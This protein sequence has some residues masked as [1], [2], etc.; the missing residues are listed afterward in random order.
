MIVFLLKYR[1]RN[2]PAQVTIDAGVIDEEIAGNVLGVRTIHT[3]HIE[4]V[5]VGTVD[6]RP[7]CRKRKNTAVTERLYSRAS[8]FETRRRWRSSVK[9]VESQTRTISRIFSCEIVLPPSV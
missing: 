4:I 5:A 8:I 1:R 3:S 9:S 7:Q 2:L 6:D